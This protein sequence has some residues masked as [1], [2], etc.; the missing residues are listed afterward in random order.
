VHVLAGTLSLLPAKLVE[1]FGH[2]GK[3]EWKSVPQVRLVKR[4]IE[5]RRDRG[6]A[7]IL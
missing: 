2:D 1:R 3:F 4:G 5:G 7:K 6:W